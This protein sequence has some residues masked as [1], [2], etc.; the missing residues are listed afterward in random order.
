VSKQTL[1]TALKTPNRH[2]ERRASAAN[3]V[4]R[5]QDPYSGSNGERE[6]K[7]KVDARSSLTGRSLIP[8]LRTMLPPTLGPPCLVP[9]L[10][11]VACC[12]AGSLT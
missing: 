7:R 1:W 3:E 9:D 8:C 11:L 6:T 2:S 5:D 12:A 10:A 4:Q